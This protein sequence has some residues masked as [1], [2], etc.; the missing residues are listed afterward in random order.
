MAAETTVRE[1]L[2][3]LVNIVQETRAHKYARA[4]TDTHTRYRRGMMSRPTWK[5]HMESLWG[6]VTHKG[7]TAEV[8]GLLEPDIPVAPFVRT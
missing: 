5:K 1:S 4:I 6:T 2:T 8:M 7:L 3:G